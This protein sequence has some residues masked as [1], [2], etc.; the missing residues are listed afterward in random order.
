[1]VDVIFTD[2]NMPDCNGLDFVK[3][4][5][6]VP[7]VVFVTA[8]DEY[9]VESYRVSAVDY[10]LKPYS[11]QDFQN[12][13]LK[14]KQLYELK[15]ANAEANLFETNSHDYIFVRADN[16]IVKVHFDR[17]VYV[18][19]MSEYIRLHFDNG[20]SI[21]TFLSIKLMMETLPEDKFMRVHRS[22]IVAL[23][24]IESYSG[25]VIY[26]QDGTQIPVSTSHKN[27]LHKFI[28]GRSLGRK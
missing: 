28:E 14:V 2:I 9:A 15:A 4:L 24:R 8:Y 12:V 17:L 25:S 6:P 20:K 26:L 10:L 3:G 7:M 13:A 22:Y 1:M 23:D 11:Y 19:A 27:T 18:E 16:Q 5:N 21:M